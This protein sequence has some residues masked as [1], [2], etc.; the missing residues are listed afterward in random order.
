MLARGGRDASQRPLAPP[1]KL[2]RRPQPASVIVT[3]PSLFTTSCASQSTRARA[4]SI[5]TERTFFASTSSRSATDSLRRRAPGLRLL[6]CRLIAGIVPPV[7]D[8]PR[9]AWRPV[10][11]RRRRSRASSR[12]SCRGE[13]AGAVAQLEARQPVRVVGD[14]ATPGV[15]HRRVDHVRHV[16]RVAVDLRVAEEVGGGLVLV[17]DRERQV[18]G[19]RERVEDVAVAEVV[20][21]LRL[22]LG[23]GYGTSSSCTASRSGTARCAARRACLLVLVD[24]GRR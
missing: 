19:L 16:R 17:V 4:G 8:R 23:P 7:S 18:V 3:G 13:R 15:V 10:P 5:V 20:E 12:R 24:C 9:A 14:G 2:A 11:G 1:A 22:R 6:A 21:G